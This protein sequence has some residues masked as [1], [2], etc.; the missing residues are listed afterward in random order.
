MNPICVAARPMAVR[1]TREVQMRATQ[2]VAATSTAFIFAAAL[3]ISPALA[4]RRIAL[5]GS[6]SRGTVK[7]DCAGAGGDYYS[8][9]GHYGCVNVNN[10]NAV[11]CVKGKCTGVVPR[12]IA[13][14]HSLGGI[15]HAPSAGIKSSGGKPPPHGHRPPV[16]VGGYKPPSRIKTTGGNNPPSMIM[17]HEEHHSGGHK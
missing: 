2:I 1:S 11:D 17:R 16:K 12:R 9:G 7:T 5:G 13:P 10:G 8:T 6:Y 15:L 3:T 14:S 4:Y